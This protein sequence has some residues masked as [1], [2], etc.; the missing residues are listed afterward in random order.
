MLSRAPLQRI[1]WV[2]QEDTVVAFLP[3]DL[4]ASGVVVLNAS[5]PH[6]GQSVAHLHVH[7][8]P[9]WPDDQATGHAAWTATHTS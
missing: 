4:E 5:G 3:L 7:V 8:V 9:F 1:E 6:P 2:A